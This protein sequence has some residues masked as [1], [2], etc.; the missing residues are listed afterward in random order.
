M[1]K[2]AV[3]RSSPLNIDALQAETGGGVNKSQPP[4]EV[5]AIE[6]PNMRVIEIAIKGTAALMINRF[7]SKMKD[8]ML[9][10]HVAGSAAKQKGRAK[11]AKDIKEL[12]NNARYVCTPPGGKPWDGISCGALR[13]ALVRTCSIV[14]FKMTSAKQSLFILADGEDDLE[15][16]PLIRIITDE[17]AKV[18]ERIV[19]NANGQPDVRIRPR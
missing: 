15:K 2:S 10:D 16:S 9:A 5:F 18:D 4:T 12:F 8:K 17:P 11:P 13:N 7:S 1:A 6:A 14:G 19:R 3:K